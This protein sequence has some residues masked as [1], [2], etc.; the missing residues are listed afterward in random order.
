MDGGRWGGRQLISQDYLRAATTAHANPPS[1]FGD[2]DYGY[3][4]W[5]GRRDNAFLF[6]GMLGK[7]SWASGTAASWC[8]QRRGGHRLPGEPVLRDRQ[9]LL[10]RDLPRYIPEDDSACLRLAEYAAALSDYHRAMGALDSA[11][12]P[13]LDR[14]F[15][16]SD[17]RAA[18]VGL[19][20]MVLQALHNNYTSG[21]VSVAVS[22]RGGLP[23][24]IYRE[25]EATYRLPV[26]LAAR[27]S[28]SSPSGETPIR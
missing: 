17:P 28:A 4:I 12:A 27:R 14:S 15:D 23:E 6:N 22:A 9:P 10:R 19:L 8:H 16:T 18:A 20:P 25:R 7:M 24:L 3:Q 21:V 26:G 1:E 5:V 11:A 2:F 13:F